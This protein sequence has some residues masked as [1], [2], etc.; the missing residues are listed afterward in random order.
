MT[1]NGDSLRHDTEGFTGTKAFA[2]MNAARRI[3]RARALRCAGSVENALKYIAHEL[4]EPRVETTQAQKGVG[5]RWSRSRHGRL[6]TVQCRQATRANRRHI[7]PPTP[8]VYVAML[9]V[10]VAA[11]MAGFDRLHTMRDNC[12]TMYTDASVVAAH[13]LGRTTFDQVRNKTPAVHT[14]DV[15]VSSSTSSSCTRSSPVERQSPSSRTGRAELELA[16][17]SARGSAG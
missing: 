6:R 13:A 4:F 8:L 1:L 14:Y 2:L 16:E 5:R 3:A 12:P 7:T 9:D 11:L 10:E 17:H 15:A